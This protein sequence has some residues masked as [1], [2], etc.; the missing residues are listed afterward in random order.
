V[1]PVLVAPSILSADFL[2]LGQEVEAI[3]R[4]GADWI[5]LDM[6]DGHFVPNLSFGPPVVQGLQKQSLPL[7]VHLMVEHPEMYFESLVEMKAHSVS[8]HVE[9]CTHLERALRQLRS[10]GMLAGVALNP[11]TSPEFLTYLKEAVDLVIVMTVNPGFSGQKFIAPMLP[12]VRRVREILGPKVRITVDG[13]VDPHSAPLA[14][15]AGADVLVAA[16]AIFGKSDYG[17]A[18]QALRG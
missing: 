1:N 3:T 4:G 9:A 2:K 11:S 13:G 14:R 16:S 18:I 7:D 12:K 6:M 10:H 8:V 5:H 17:A 15:D